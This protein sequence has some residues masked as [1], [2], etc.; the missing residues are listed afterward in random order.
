MWCGTGEKANTLTLHKTTSLASAAV[1]VVLA[2]AASPGPRSVP[3]RHRPPP[4]LDRVCIVPAFGAPASH[5]G[6]PQAGIS[7]QN[8]RQLTKM[9]CESAP[10]PITTGLNQHIRP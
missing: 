5:V 6:A 4:G 2:E 10:P 9:T 3:G 8:R 7:E 1:A